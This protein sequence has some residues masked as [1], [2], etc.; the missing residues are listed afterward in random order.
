MS[1]HCTIA[2]CTTAYEYCTVAY[3][4]CDSLLY[5]SSRRKAQPCCA[6]A[7]D[8][9][10]CHSDTNHGIISPSNDAVDVAVTATAVYC[11]FPPS[12]KFQETTSKH[13]Y[14]ITLPPR[15]RRTKKKNSHGQVVPNLGGKDQAA[16]DH[17]P[18]ERAEKGGGGEGR[19][20]G[21]SD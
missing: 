14:L 6:R 10:Q 17:G 20:G 15:L 7:D 11:Q 21:R 5:D 13:S 12:L 4:L 8:S 19:G 9:L 16:E 3:C 18:Y 1:A 2:Y